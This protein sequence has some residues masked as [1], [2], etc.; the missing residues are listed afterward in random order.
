MS[1]RIEPNA[2]PIPGYRLIERLGGGGF[3]EVWKAEAPGGLFKAIKFVYGEIA[4]DDS[5][6]FDDPDG[7]RAKQ[8]YKSLNRVKTVHHPYILSLERF[9]VIQG[10]LVIVMEL[11]DKTLWDRFKECRSQGLPGI[12]RD[13][14]LSYMHETAEA[15]D[16]MNTEYQLQHLDIKPQNIFLVYNHVK[17]ADF[18]LVKDLAANQQNATI[19]GGVT[20][21]YAAPETFDGWLSRQSDQYSLAIVYQELLTG[22]RPFAGSSM[23]QLIL[24][25][26]QS[27]PD[28]TLLP[29]ADRPIVAKA[30]SKNPEERYSACLDFVRLLQGATQAIKATNPEIKSPNAS[31]STP[32]PMDT[33]S[34]QTAGARGNVGPVRPADPN[35]STEDAFYGSRPQILPPRPER[36]IEEVPGAAGQPTPGVKPKKAE[37]THSTQE[38]P[39]IL[40]PGLIIGLGQ[41]GVETLSQLRR[42]LSEEFG[43]PDAVP[44]LR[45]IA[46]DTDT[47]TIQRAVNDTS[48]AALRN[49]EVVWSRLQRPGSYIKT[50][51]GKLPTD[52]WLNPKL[53]YRIP[54]EQ[55]NAGL[56]AL[57]RLAF[58]DNYRM[59]ARRIEAELL[60]CAP[61]EPNHHA[62]SPRG[63]G[64]R[65]T[66]PRVYITTSLT[67]NTG[68]GMFL[69]VAY[70]VRKLL[71]NQGHEDAEIIGLFFVPTVRRD[72]G[73][74]TPLM[75]TYASLVELHHFSQR[76]SLFTARYET[77]TSSNKDN[78]TE[79]GP[80]FQRCLM[81]PLPELNGPVSANDNLLAAAAAG[82]F[83][84]RDLATVLGPAVDEQRRIK[85]SMSN[86]WQ[87]GKGPL[88]Q[89]LNM[90]R[91][92]WPRHA[93]LEHCARQ[94]CQQLVT[95][96][97]SKDA[98]VMVAT[99]S[100]WT[101]ERWESLGMRPESLIERFH[102]LTEHALRQT[103]E[104]L[105]T[106]MLDPL[107]EALCGPDKDPKNVSV[108]AIMQ[109]MSRLETALGSPEESRGTTTA[110]PELSLVERT[111]TDIA[112]VIADESEQQ[113]AKLAV[114]LLE[115]PNYRLAG[116]EEALRQFCAV[117]E[118]SLQS[119]ETLAKELTEKAALLHQR[120][121]GLLDSPAKSPEPTNTTLKIN[122]N[123]RAAGKNL[124]AKDIFDL[125]RTYAK[126]RYH[127][128][129]LTYLN[130]LYVG[131][132]GH[133][134][135]QI[136]EVGF[137]R[138][139]LSELHGL[140]LAGATAA[141]SKGGGG[142]G[143]IKNDKQIGERI[144]FP[145][146]CLAMS[147]AIDRLKQD[148]TSEDLLS[149][150]ERIQAW[151]K[152][153][154]QALLQVCM[155]SSSMVKNLA[156]VMVQEAEAFLDVRLR[157]AS[158]A[159]MY[160]DH[161][162]GDKED[163]ECSIR[164]DLESCYDEAAPDLGRLSELNELAVV[165][166]PN[167]EAGKRVQELL[168]KQLPDL[169]VVLTDRHDEMV[170]FREIMNIPWK[171]L[172]QL[173]TIAQQAY[174][175]RFQSDPSAPHS[176]EDI[177]EWQSHSSTHR[178][179]TARE[180]AAKA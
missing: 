136:R 18:G 58:V 66:T 21:V 67:G 35:F 115:D 12:P 72:A 176:R 170:F 150:D 132:R 6:A 103:P 146:G 95:R 129:I 155:G 84:C 94:L 133:L 162:N 145:A 4:S 63:I 75:N 90:Y 29:V 143:S 79:A 97:M 8:E 36:S 134:S 55:N 130:R 3:G 169:K 70:L 88:L 113:L 124:S 157:G 73:L 135:D 149:F 102:T 83:L 174:E 77:A 74:A 91:I 2:E 22:Q 34:N 142:R 144:L 93:V 33:R 137:C 138:Q 37:S 159:E 112:H 175:S 7:S 151:I 52:S 154:C 168:K 62:K 64:V 53:I 165:C 85:M 108:G 39:G 152:T 38:L 173:G 44:Q 122:L 96:W 16:L 140:L 54:R 117:V 123:K 86:E 5:I 119:Q 69:D 31:M 107:R 125:V 118:Q 167:D 148:L 49:H 57:G 14:L 78:V 178:E 60:A 82:D 89:S 179:I 126:T 109:A 25:H 40:Q 45:M 17:V 141:P 81:F 42:R 100:Q 9:G 106:E 111:L 147:D 11:A 65:S 26:L 120:I 163:A 127:S 172:E 164:E 160:L 59:I 153:N 30:L 41:L 68:S 19:T 98:K 161:Q 158:V 48:R 116:A 1:L 56:R 80:A 101:Q 47:D 166:L 139:R 46:I 10:Q 50:R 177:I 99:I 121:V 24:H 32:V 104:Q 171:D 23:K 71:R 128:L 110:Q 92:L 43:L 61:K 76:E 51:D 180:A 131:L 105:M 28:L 87:L 27:A 20:P 156:P 13:E 15:L 114:Q